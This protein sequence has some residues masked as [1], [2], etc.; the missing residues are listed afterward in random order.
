MNHLRTP[1][2]GKLKQ[3]LSTRLSKRGPKNRV[4][5]PVT[6]TYWAAEQDEVQTSISLDQRFKLMRQVGSSTIAYSAVVQPRLHYFTHSSRGQTQPDG[7]IAYR[8]RW[9]LTFALGDPVVAEEH[10]RDILEEFVAA[11]F[12]PSFCQVSESTAEILDSMGYYVNQMGVDTILDLPSYDFYGKDKEWL[13][14]AANWTARRGYTI[15][16]VGFDEIDVDGIEAIS[17]AWRKTRTIKHKEVRFLNRPIVLTDEPGVRKFYLYSPARQPL[18]FIFLDP[19]YRN[20]KIFGYVT[21]IKRRHPDAPLYAEHAIMKHVIEI[22][23]S[24]NVEQIRLG[25]SP[26]ANIEDGHLRASRF[27]RWLFKR[28]FNSRLINSYFYN[29]QGHATYKR[30]FRG[31]EVKTYYAS[32][33]RIDIPRQ[34]A[35]IGLCGLA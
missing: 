9:G 30:R 4:K 25:L 33:V 28:G 17:E 5:V 22:L 3:R 13:R 26:G 35:L 16:E 21:A 32:P 29:L 2:S 7:F 10:L 12:K 8:R 15:D 20:G 1:S 27:T 6:Q 14:Y 31:R 18:A 24:E 19:L 34:A 23:K 11:N